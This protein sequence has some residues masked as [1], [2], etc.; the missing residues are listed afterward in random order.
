MLL[1]FTSVILQ[2]NSAREKEKKTKEKE[3][4]NKETTEKKQRRG[5]TYNPGKRERKNRQ[6]EQLLF[7]EQK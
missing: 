3:K 2:K 6:K 1:L 5:Q 4:E 7:R